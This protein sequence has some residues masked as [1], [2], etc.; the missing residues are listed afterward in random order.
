M[1][2]VSCLIASAQPNLW[3]PPAQFMELRKT[4]PDRIERLQHSVMQ[5]PSDAAAIVKQGAQSLFGCLEGG[6]EAA[7]GLF[8]QQ[9]RNR[10]SCV[11]R[12]PL[13]ERRT[14]VRRLA[15]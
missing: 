8:L 12:N 9:V 11:L 6:S 7:T 13:S 15:R 1:E 3:H 5:F 4:Q 2:L 14:L 10:L